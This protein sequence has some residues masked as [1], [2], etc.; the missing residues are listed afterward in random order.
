M[1]V[2]PRQRLIEAGGRADDSAGFRSARDTPS[3]EGHHRC[4]SRDVISWRPSAGAES[5]KTH[6]GPRQFLCLAQR[7]EDPD[8]NLGFTPTRLLLR[9][10]ALPRRKAAKT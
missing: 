5:A 3:R 6:R 9:A 1:L 2:Q 7:V 8:E 4:H 10:L